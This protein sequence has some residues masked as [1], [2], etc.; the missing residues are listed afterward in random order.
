MLNFQLL[1]VDPPALIS[2]S[3][4][5][6]KPPPLQRFVRPFFCFDKIYLIRATESLSAE[7]VLEVGVQT[8]N[9]IITQLKKR[10]G[11]KK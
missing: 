5:A 6:H 4:I 8:V 11:G 1:T 2:V 7:N 3:K 10:N 9:K